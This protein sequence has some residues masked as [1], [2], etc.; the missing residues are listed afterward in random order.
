MK[1]SFTLGTV[2]FHKKNSPKHKA[3]LGGAI[4]AFLASIILFSVGLNEKVVFALS[5]APICLILAVILLFVAI[6]FCVE[7]C[8]TDRMVICKM[9]FGR[10]F[11]IKLDTIGKVSTFSFGQQLRIQGHSGRIHL[12]FVPYFREAEAI[13]LGVMVSDEREESSTFT[14]ERE[15]TSRESEPIHVT[16]SDSDDSLPEL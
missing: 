13:L 2:L 4:A 16:S 6:H 7:F 11:Q 12:I 9:S 8:V 14:Y 5:L 10:N 1:K 3:F 15:S